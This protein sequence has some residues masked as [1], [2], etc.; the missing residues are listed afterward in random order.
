MSF[1][2]YFNNQC[3]SFRA[4]FNNQCLSFREKYSKKSIV[5]LDHISNNE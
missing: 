5:K 4:Y 2:A 1:R 3:L